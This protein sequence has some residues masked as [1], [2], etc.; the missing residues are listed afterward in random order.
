M[1]CPE[2]TPPLKGQN[3]HE[4]L[5]RL[6]NFRLTQKQQEF[7]KDARKM[8]LKMAPKGKS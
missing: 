1:T 3:A 6:R 4:F 8:Y 5:E 2:P 7:N